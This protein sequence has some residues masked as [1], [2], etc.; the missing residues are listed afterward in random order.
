MKREAPSIEFPKTKLTSK[1]VKIFKQEN[2]FLLDK[3]KDPS[4]LYKYK[5]L[6]DEN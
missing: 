6:I 3:I 5:Y 1:L 2:Y 4:L